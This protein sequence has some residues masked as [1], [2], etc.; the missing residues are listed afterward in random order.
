MESQRLFRFPILRFPNTQAAKAAAIY[1][2][3]ALYA[4]GFWAMVDASIFSKTV[5]ASVV[6][7]T[8]VD[9]IPF[10]CSTLGTITVNMIDKKQLMASDSFGS[11]SIRWQARLVLFIGCTLL[12]VGMSGSALLV[13]L[14]YVIKGY[15]SMP[16][17]GM[18]L[19]NIYATGSITLSC[20]ILWVVQNVEEDY[21]YSLA[22]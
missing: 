1:I 13:I 21:N 12:A 2:S 18:A 5:N 6:H 11:G 8:F 15:T 17:L 14:K 10:I 3:G 7:V 19:E 20:I 22:L 16:T 4:I 9:W